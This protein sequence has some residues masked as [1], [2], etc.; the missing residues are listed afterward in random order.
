MNSIFGREA[1]FRRLNYKGEPTGEWQD[2]NGFNLRTDLVENVGRGQPR[3]DLTETWMPKETKISFNRK[4]DPVGFFALELLLFQHAVLG[5]NDDHSAFVS[6]MRWDR[7]WFPTMQERVWDLKQNYLDTV[8]LNGEEPPKWF[9]L[10]W[11]GQYIRQ[12]ETP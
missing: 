1:R 4:E 7:Q 11:V 12:Q 8:R 3:Y 2:L 6:E 5:R 10:W 9:A